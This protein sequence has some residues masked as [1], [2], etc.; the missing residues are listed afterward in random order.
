M[1]I[2]RKEQ[3]NDQVGPWEA[4]NN[5][6]VKSKLLSEPSNNCS[7]KPS[8]GGCK[9]SVCSTSYLIVLSA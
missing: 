8:E 2:K 7:A 1:S 6:K 9:T 5:Q 3:K 4:E